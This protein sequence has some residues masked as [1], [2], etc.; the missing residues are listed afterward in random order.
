[1]MSLASAGTSS[2]WVGNS[3]LSLSTFC[4][5]FEARGLLTAFLIL[6]SVLLGVVAAR[7]AYSKLC[8]STLQPLQAGKL[9]LA[10]PAR[11]FFLEASASSVSSNACAAVPGLQL[12]IKA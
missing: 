3:W 5:V 1:M 8:S 11:A 9:L 12:Q 10:E 2:A 6:A 7:A 4:I